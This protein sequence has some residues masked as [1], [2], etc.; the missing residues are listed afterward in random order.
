M[1]DNGCSSGTAPIAQALMSQHPNHLLSV[2]PIRLCHTSRSWR[3]L[4]NLMPLKCSTVFLNISPLPSTSQIRPLPPVPC[5]VDVA[6]LRREYA[7]F[8]LA[9]AYDLCPW[10]KRLG[11][12]AHQQRAADVQHLIGPCCSNICMKLQ[13]LWAAATDLHTVSLFWKDIVRHTACFLPW[14]ITIHELRKSFLPLYQQ[15]DY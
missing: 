14:P 1:Y 15:H 6:I 8:W 4:T 2:V 7:C 9:K 12:L 13:Q 11:L 3:S 10:V 5:A